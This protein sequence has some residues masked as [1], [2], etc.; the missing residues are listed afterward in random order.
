MF[1]CPYSKLFNT[2]GPINTF[3]FDVPLKVIENI[4]NQLKI[5]LYPPLHNDISD[6][7]IQ[8]VLLKNRLKII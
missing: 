6:N 4:E 5:F 3:E 2:F 8:L 1:M 7:L